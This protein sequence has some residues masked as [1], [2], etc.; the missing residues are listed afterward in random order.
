MKQGCK[1]NVYSPFLFLLFFSEEHNV[2]IKGR[3]V[4]LGL[5][6]KDLSWPNS[7]PSSA[8]VS[9]MIL[10]SARDMWSGNGCNFT[11]AFL[12]PS[13]HLQSWETL[14]CLKR[15]LWGWVCHCQCSDIWLMRNSLTYLWW[16]RDYILP[17]DLGSHPL[18][19]RCPPGPHL[20][21]L[22]WT[23]RIQ[24]LP[25]VHWGTIFSPSSIQGPL[26]LVHWDA[27]RS[28]SSI[29]AP[30]APLLHQGTKR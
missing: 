7:S 26:L 3:K 25:L 1:L 29:Q 21:W 5:I 13:S 30:H 14:P 24:E 11:W 28:T 15:W 20:T 23:S 17:P 19:S 6:R 10:L 18:P 27:M 12:A 22:G 9:S 4:E 8:V 16:N 2:K